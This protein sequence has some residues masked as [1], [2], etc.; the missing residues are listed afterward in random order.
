MSKTA[1]LRAALLALLEEHR[2]DRRVTD[3]RPVS[4]LVSKA[5]PNPNAL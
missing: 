1:R 4:F 5:A 2:R 3:Q